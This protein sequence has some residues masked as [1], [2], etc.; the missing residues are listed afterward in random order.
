MLE[1]NRNFTEEKTLRLKLETSLNELQDANND[2]KLKFDTNL[3]E[4]NQK[5]ELQKDVL[6]K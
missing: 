1:I 6:N 2:Q 5:Y 4:L 3:V